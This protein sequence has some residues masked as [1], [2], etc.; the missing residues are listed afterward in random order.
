MDATLLEMGGTIGVVAV[1]YK[2]LDIV[3]KSVLERMKERKSGVRSNGKCGFDLT[4]RDTLNGLMGEI[5]SSIK[6]Q[7][8][9]LRLLLDRKN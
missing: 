9:M 5:K 8:E 1:C 7:E 6:I 4:C 3:S 2:A